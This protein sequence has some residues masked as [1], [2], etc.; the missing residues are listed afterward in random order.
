MTN[1]P[2]RSRVLAQEALVAG[3]RAIGQL[4]NAHFESFDRETSDL[5]SAIAGWLQKHDKRHP[6]NQPR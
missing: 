6:S 2:N 1:H 5:L 3:V 4:V